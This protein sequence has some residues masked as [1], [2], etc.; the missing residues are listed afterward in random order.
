MHF[1]TDYIVK[2]LDSVISALLLLLT[3][4]SYTSVQAD[5]R[6]ARHYQRVWLLFYKQMLRAL[7]AFLCVI[8][9]VMQAPHV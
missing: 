3:A 7:V 9:N 5:L 2:Q 8:I 4:C 1:S 6:Y